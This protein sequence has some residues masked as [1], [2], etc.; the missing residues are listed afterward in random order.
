MFKNK[1]VLLLAVGGA[2]V[3]ALAMVAAAAATTSV[4]SAQ[5]APEA[6]EV[7][8]AWFGLGGDE[9]GYGHGGR[10]GFPGGEA[11]DHSYLADALGMSVEDVEAA[12]QAAW[13]KAI[14]QA[15]AEELITEE[16]AAE[17]REAGVG[18]HSL[19]FKRGLFDLGSESIDFNGLLADELGITVEELD[20]AHETA[21]EAAK[22]EIQEKIEN[23][24]LP[25]RGARDGF[26]GG[27]RERPDGF[28]GSEREMPAGREAP[29][30]MEGMRDA[31]GV[32]REYMDPQAWTAEALGMTVEELEAAHEDGATMP[33]LLEDAGLTGEEFQQA[34]QD[35]YDAALAQAVEDGVIT[36]EQADMMK[37]MGLRGKRGPGGMPGRSGGPE[38]RGGFGEG[39][40]F[41]CPA[42]ENGEAPEGTDL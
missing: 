16:E 38:G 15:V 30:G 31:A 40:D 2:L 26:K 10:G 28:D 5:G 29:E 34:M 39:S 13:E 27:Q 3:A 21:R 32:M 41:D 37:E 9:D 20:A 11:P 4:V 36:Q 14:D 8:A 1:K 33:E 25:E 23:G 19:R 6:I 7:G 18:S 35:A 22:A 24:E 17:I 12:Y 42:P